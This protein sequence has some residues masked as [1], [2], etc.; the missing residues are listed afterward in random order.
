MNGWS[1][2]ISEPAMHGILALLNFAGAWFSWKCLRF[3]AL[4]MCRDGLMQRIANGGKVYGFQRK[5]CGIH[6]T[7]NRPI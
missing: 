7:E 4:G 3:M 5:F 2:E 6:P 1:V